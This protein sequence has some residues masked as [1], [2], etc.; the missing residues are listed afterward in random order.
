MPEENTSLEKPVKEFVSNFISQVEDGLS[1][2]NWESCSETDSHA[3]ID[4]VATAINEAGAGIKINLFNLNAKASDSQS[5]KI[6]IF[7]RKKDDELRSLER[8]AKISEAKFKRAK[9]GY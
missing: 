6:T 7:V 3:K 9:L 2:R 4:L 5:Q 1:E 8:A